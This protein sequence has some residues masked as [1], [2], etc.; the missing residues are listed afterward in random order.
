MEL[1]LESPKN[2]ASEPEKIEV[3]PQKSDIEI[4]APEAPTTTPETV[5]TTEKVVTT[6]K[7]NVNKVLEEKIN[8]MS[9]TICDYEL[10]DLRAKIQRDRSNLKNGH[11]KRERVLERMYDAIADASYIVE[12]GNP[13]PEKKSEMQAYIETVIA[14]MER[15]GETVEA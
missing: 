14:E 9:S 4:T 13:T 15:V 1:E 7:G 12:K 3:T 5:T 10:K 8:S 6:K 11:G 2:G